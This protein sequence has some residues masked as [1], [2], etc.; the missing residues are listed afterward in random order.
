[1][2]ISIFRLSSRWATGCALILWIL[3]TSC[4]NQPE[5]PPQPPTTP[6][7]LV[8]KYG[9]WGG[10]NPETEDIKIIP[11]SVLYTFTYRDSSGN[12]KST[13]CTSFLNKPSYD[14]IY[15]AI[16]IPRFNKLPE[17]TGCPGCADGKVEWIEITSPSS[18][19]KVTFEPADAPVEVQKILPFLRRHLADFKYCQK[20]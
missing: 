11:T 4:R 7:N 8:I 9:I 16:N 12:S 19:H 1:M 18:S 10:W 17:V 5:V 20:K 14:S 15:F 13:N 6:D 3:A 2:K